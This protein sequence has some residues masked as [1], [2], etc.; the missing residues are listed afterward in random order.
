MGEVDILFRDRR[1]FYFRPIWC[2]SRS[3]WTNF[4]GSSDAFWTLRA[5]HNNIPRE[6]R[7]RLGG[8]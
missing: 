8:W 7:T 1:S 5:A 3:R 2:R 6:S 4:V